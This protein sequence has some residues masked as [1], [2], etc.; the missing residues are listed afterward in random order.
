[1]AELKDQGCVER[2]SYGKYSIAILEKKGEAV[3]TNILIHMIEASK[4]NLILRAEPTP[5]NLVK[6][7]RMYEQTKN[8]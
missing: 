1:M 6:A 2:I 8:L 5:E 3:V 7:M 4:G